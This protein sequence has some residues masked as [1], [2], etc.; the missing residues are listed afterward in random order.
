VKYDVWSSSTYER[1][2]WGVQDEVYVVCCLLCVE[3]GIYV[4]GEILVC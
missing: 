4:N 2:I 1:M 3:Y